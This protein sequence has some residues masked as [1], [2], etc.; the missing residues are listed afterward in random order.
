[1]INLHSN[2]TKEVGMDISSDKTLVFFLIRNTFMKDIFLK[3]KV[4]LNLIIMAR[5][6]LKNQSISDSLR[7]VS[8]MGKANI[9]KYKT[10]I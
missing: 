2:S 10:M 4:N 1:M 8:P 5:I 3:I 6:Y 9:L 7:M